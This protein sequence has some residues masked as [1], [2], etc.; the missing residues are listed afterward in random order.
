MHNITDSPPPTPPSTNNVGD[1][2]KMQQRE[3]HLTSSS[4]FWPDEN[5]GHV[6]H[7]LRGGLVGQLHLFVLL[8]VFRASSVQRSRNTGHGRQRW[9]W[10]RRHRCRWRWQYR[11]STTRKRKSYGLGP[12]GKE[13]SYPVQYWSS[14]SSK[15]YGQDQSSTI[16]HSAQRKSRT[17]KSCQ[18]RL[19]QALCQRFGRSGETLKLPVLVWPKQGTFSI[20]PPLLIEFPCFRIQ[21]IR[22]FSPSEKSK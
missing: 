21:F 19:Q 17:R 12:G 22:T 20:F 14:W 3:T 6:L 18:H 16:H 4:S 15:R 7:D 2:S 9:W 1:V 13:R 8:P 11:G 10:R 5:R